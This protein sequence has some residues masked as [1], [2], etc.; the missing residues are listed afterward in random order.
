MRS[1]T[2]LAASPALVTVAVVAAG[3]AYLLG[4]TWAMGHV[5]YDVWGALV[6]IPLIAAAAI[7]F[8]R[9]VFRGEPVVV[10]RV[11]MLGL[12]AKLGGTLARYWV[13]VD[14]YGGAADSTAYHIAGRQIAGDAHDGLITILGLIPHSQ[15]TR[16][17]DELTGFIYTFV[18]A[19]KLA[20]FLWFAALGYAGVVLSVKAACIAVPGLLKRRYALLCFLMPSIVFWPSGIGKEAWMSLCLGALSVGAARLFRGDSIARAVLWIAAGAGGAAMVRPHMAAIWLAGVVL[21][22]TWAVLGGRFGVTVSRPRGSRRAVLAGFTLVA[23]IALVGVAQVTLKYLNPPSEESASVSDQVSNVFELTT[24]RTSGGG[25]ELVPVV[26]TGPLDYPEAVIR[27]LT[28]PLLYEAN[29]LATLLPALEMTFVLA[30]LVVGWRSLAALPGQL[31][32]APFVVYATLVCIMFGL[33]FTTL[34]NLAI[35]VRQRSLVMPMMLLLCCLPA[36]VARQP[37]RPASFTA[38]TRT[39]AGGGARPA[40][41]R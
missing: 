14:A 3:L 31:R 8:V 23:V 19:S 6:A 40:L 24:K 18:G 12:L 2:R 25:S 33:A 32:R 17:I 20:G 16:F 15:G 27:T 22:L 5:S 1:P 4:T 28:R 10:M 41:S 9:R 37:A 21:S 29:S 38:D 36:R 11:A 13:A 7:P 39:G 35:L 30:M 26:V 34:A